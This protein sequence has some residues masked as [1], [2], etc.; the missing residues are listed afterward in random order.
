MYLKA[1]PAYFKWHTQQM[2]KYG[3]KVWVAAVAKNFYSYNMPV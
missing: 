1:S 3:I 2:V